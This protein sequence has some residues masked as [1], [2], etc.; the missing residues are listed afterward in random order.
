[1]KDLESKMSGAKAL[2]ETLE[3][4]KV[5]VIFG[6]IGG[7]ILPVYDELYDS[8]IRHILSR[9]EQ[10]AAHAADGYARASG[11]PGICMATSGPG[12]TNL[13]TGIATAYMDSSPMI[14]FTGQVN[15]YSPNT[16]YMIGRD[17]FQ[18]A[19]IIGITTPITKYN[20][21]VQNASEV[22][23]MVKKAFYVATT[24]RPGPV[25]I[26]LPK[27]V[28]TE[29]A[30]V[31]FSDKI[32][33]P[34][35]KPPAKPHLLQIKKAAEMLLNAERPIVL[36]GGGVIIANATQELLQ[37]AESLIMPVATSLMGKGA[38]PENHP[39]SL[40]TIG[41]HGTQEANKLMLEADVMLAVGTRFS[42]R[43]CATIDGFC[44]DS[45]IIHVDID[46]AEIEKN[47]GVQVPIVGDAKITLKK[48]NEIIKKQVKKK[49]NT[50]WAKRVKEVQEQLGTKANSEE[51]Q[52][53]D[54]RII[55]KEL[56]RMLPEDAI[57]T[58][59][60]GQNQ[61]WAGLYF[62]TLKPRT[63]ITSGGLGTMGFGFPAALGAKVA[64]PE[65]IVVDVAGDGSFRMTEQE[66]ASSVMEKIPVTVVILNNS[67]LG[68]VAQWQR[69]FYNRRCFAVNLGN[70]PDFVKLAEAYGA[71][72]FRVETKKEFSKA[73]KTAMNNEVTTVID[74]PIATDK[75]VFPMIPPG[76]GLKDIVAE[77]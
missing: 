8:K 71:Q 31:E 57:I 44:P 53:L 10:G 26:D 54:P 12:A 43:S 49:G 55:L 61:M 16:T 15:T 46:A 41:M 30:K 60:V 34:G 21:Q 62:E 73:L 9:H 76:R 58:T 42:D 52:N 28:Q 20:Y 68:M 56:R 4:K 36:A 50:T 45:K 69:M 11:K 22:P 5:E 29:I 6:I 1:M 75:N 39:L 67:V 18:E 14:A 27:N 70:V 37:L 74:V 59:E 2:V 7:A 40:G 48:L 17:A 72:G 33:V 77:P 24:G 19:D 51:G 66:L 65:R 13:V 23:R 38:F 25:L 64:C 35:F 63:F 3:R 32:K 47:I